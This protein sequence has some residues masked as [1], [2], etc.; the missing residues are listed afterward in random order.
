MIIVKGKFWKPFNRL[1]NEIFQKKREIIISFNF[2]K[3]FK[4]ENKW[5]LNLQEKFQKQNAKEN[6]NNN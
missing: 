2:S 4:N 5:G 6:D 3:Y 1:W